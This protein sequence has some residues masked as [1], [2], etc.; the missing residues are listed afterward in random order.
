MSREDTGGDDLAVTYRTT[1]V[2]CSKRIDHPC[3]A[4]PEDSGCDRF[5]THEPAIVMWFVSVCLNPRNY[6]FL[7][8]V[9]YV[10]CICQ[11]SFGAESRLTEGQLLTVFIDIEFLLFR[12]RTNDK[13]KVRYRIITEV[14]LWFNNMQKIKYSLSRRCLN[15]YFDK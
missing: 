6:Q 3:R 1:A 4:I 8:M 7:L 5:K 15:F 9:V 13:S 12:V 10:L 11:L 2:C 14:E